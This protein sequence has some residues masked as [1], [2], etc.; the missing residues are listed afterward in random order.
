M[1]SDLLHFELTSSI[2][3][4]CFEV[5]N[6]LGTGFVE[7]VYKNALLISLRDKNFSI[8]RERSFEVYFK[9]EKVGTYKPD[10]IVQ[11]SMIVEL[12]CCK[13]LLAEH[14]AQTINYLKITGMPI[15]LLI[16]FGNKK[17]EYKRLRHPCLQGDLC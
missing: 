17:L 12:K 9:G 8:E 14:Q 13:C 5:M 2:L 16:N 15:G 6:E 3:N 4:S 10:L 7:C 11:Q 1:N